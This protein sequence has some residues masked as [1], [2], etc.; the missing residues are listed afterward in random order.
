MNPGAGV[1]SVEALHEW[2]AA[3]ASFREEAGDALTSMALTLQRAADWLDDQ[4]QYWQREIRAC[5]EELTQAKTE[6]TNRE[7]TDFLGHKLDTSL[8]EENLRK[9]KGRLAFAEERLDSVQRWRKRLPL[10][11]RETYD[12][13]VRHLGFLL[14]T[15]LPRGLAVLARQINALEQYVNIRSD[16]ASVPVAPAPKPE[17]KKP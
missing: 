6:L 9:A 2:Y 10:E 1:T 5:E 8:Q 13:P 12:G 15:E 4:Q 17:E 11:V 14:E 7:F 3:L 16:G